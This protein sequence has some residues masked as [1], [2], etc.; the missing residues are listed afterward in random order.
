[1]TSVP[2][3]TMTETHVSWLFFVGDRVYKVKKPVRFG[4]VDLTDRDVR[5][6]VCQAEVDLNR[7]LEPDVYEGVGTF[8]GPSGDAEP[9]VVMKR[10]P[11]DRRLSSLVDRGQPGVDGHVIRIANKLVAFHG[12][13]LR[14][15]DIDHDCAPQAVAGLWRRNLA[16]LE[17]V[18]GGIVSAEAIDQVGRLGEQYLAGRASLFR[19]RIAGGHAVD[20]HGDLLADD[21]FCLEDGPRILDCLEFDDSLRHV[22]TLLDLA[23]LAMDLERLGRRDLGDRLLAGYGK[24]SGD[25]WP[26]TLAHF[27]I[28]YRATVRAK[29][30]C[31][32]TQSGDV[33]AERD[34]RRLMVMARRRLEVG[35][36]RLVLVGGLPGTGKSTLAREL[37]RKTG[38]ALVRSDLI[39]KG[40]SGNELEAGTPAGFATGRYA[41]GMSAQVYSGMIRTADTLLRSGQCVI[42]DASWSETAF[43]RQARALADQTHVDVIELRCEAPADVAE[44]RIRVRI[45]EGRDPSEATPDIARA[46]ARVFQ[47]WPE[48]HR[49]E[50]SGSV[51]DATRASIEAIGPTSGPSGWG[52]S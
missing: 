48:A 23:S 12:A 10:L 27:Y 40:L 30:A 2:D 37:Q 1:M 20:G 47:P 36:V 15:P 16:E 8:V 45:D 51:E 50:T 42:M 33:G 21:I 46:M 31:I 52:R 26:A 7:R 11:D 22:D 13:A 41:P 4:F 38:S 6:T 29:V 17:T 39:R 14:G 49:I 18:A 32:R 24:L 25:S 35:T 9:V 19:S 5:R 43:R 28:A 3:V 44:A 34:A